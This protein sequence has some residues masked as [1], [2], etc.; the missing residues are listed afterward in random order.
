[1]KNKSVLLYSALSRVC[2]VLVNA[3]WCNVYMKLK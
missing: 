3:I 2:N 1:M